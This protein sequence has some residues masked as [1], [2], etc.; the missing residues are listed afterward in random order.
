MRQSK[1]EHNY[2]YIN[3]LLFFCQNLCSSIVKQLLHFSSESFIDINQ[4]VT[5]NFEDEMNELLQFGL[6]ELTSK[7]L[8]AFFKLVITLVAESREEYQK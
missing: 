8:S 2:P 3:D 5:F 6:I 4:D 7:V 1:N